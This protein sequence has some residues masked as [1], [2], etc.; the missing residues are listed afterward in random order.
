MSQL[1]NLTSPEAYE[2]IQQQEAVLIDI[3]STIEHQFVGHPVD[4]VHIP[5]SDGP[6]WARNDNFVTDVQS[7]LYAKNSQD[8]PKQQP[9]VLMCRSGAR[10]QSAGAA[11]IDAGF[12][13]VAHVSDGFEGDKDSN[14]HRGN[15]NGWRFFNLPWVQT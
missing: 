11:L 3:R 10:T 7:L 14:H 5:W 8:E 4:A 15:I 6:D 1:V 2:F 9:V 12:T 13:N